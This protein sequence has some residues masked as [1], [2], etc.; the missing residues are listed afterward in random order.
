MMNKCQV[1]RIN[2]AKQFRGMLT[3]DMYLPDAQHLVIHATW[4]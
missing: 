1:I 3:A 4:N 2:Y